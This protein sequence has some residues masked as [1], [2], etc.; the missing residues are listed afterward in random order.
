MAGPHAVNRL[1]ERLAEFKETC[2]DAIDE[3]RGQLVNEKEREA[4]RV[5]FAE[6]ANALKAT[7]AGHSANVGMAVR[8]SHTHTPCLLL[9][10]L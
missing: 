5:A 1:G 8:R 9:S 3:L 10:L 4:A 2:E 6:A 7:F